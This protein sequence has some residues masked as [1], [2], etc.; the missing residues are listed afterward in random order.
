MWGP[1]RWWWGAWAA[2]TSVA[3]ASGWSCRNSHPCSGEPWACPRTCRDWLQRFERHRERVEQMFDAAFARAWRLY[4][5][6]SVAG[7]TSGS[8]QLFQVVFT[9]REN[10]A[11][12]MTR[13]HLYTPSDEAVPDA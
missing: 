13:E 8:L 7:F 12:P 2:I 4:L 5:A 9:H 3:P 11:V 1:S 10:N 6:G